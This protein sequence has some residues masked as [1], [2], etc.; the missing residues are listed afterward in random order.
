MI[1]T[2]L[3]SP[4]HRFSYSCKDFISCELFLCVKERKGSE[5][6]WWKG[7]SWLVKSA[8]THLLCLL[9]FFKSCLLMWMSR[10]RRV[11]KREKKIT[12]ERR[13]FFLSC[14]VIMIMYAQRY[15]F[16]LPDDSGMNQ[17]KVERE[18]WWEVIIAHHHHNNHEMRNAPK[19]ISYILMTVMIHLQLQPILPYDY[20]YFLETLLIFFLL[21]WISSPFASDVSNITLSLSLFRILYASSSSSHSFLGL[22]LLLLFPFWH[23]LLS[24]VSFL[25]SEPDRTDIRKSL[26]L[27]M[28]SL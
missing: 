13:R 22:P 16:L 15:F 9:L 5:R 10:K 4:E 28:R 17:C 20:Y 3:F 27:L 1:L 2:L 12:Y 25:A 11:E 6:K 19:I 23:L 21:L 26:F 14:C 7:L 18:E 24:N 8:W